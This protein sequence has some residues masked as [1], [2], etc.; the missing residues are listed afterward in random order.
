MFQNYIQ[1][2]PALEMLRDAYIYMALEN[3]HRF[4]YEYSKYL[5]DIKCVAK[6]ICMCYS[7]KHKEQALHI[8][9]CIC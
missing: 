6:Y 5:Y 9:V 3:E 4:A 8:M 7:K 1:K 2:I